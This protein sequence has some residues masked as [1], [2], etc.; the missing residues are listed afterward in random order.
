[1]ILS[2]ISVIQ[3]SIFYV[4]V[5]NL[6]WDQIEEYWLEIKEDYGAEHTIIESMIAYF[7]LAAYYQ[8][9]PLCHRVPITL[10]NLKLKC[11]GDMEIQYIFD[12]NVVN[13]DSTLCSDYHFDK[14]K[15][16]FQQ[17]A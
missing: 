13:G 7:S 11:K 15:N 3:M 9:Y 4:D 2:I 14:I 17:E 10:N 16:I 1:M 6:N 5:Q 12:A 8:A